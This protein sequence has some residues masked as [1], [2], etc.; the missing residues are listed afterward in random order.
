MLAAK[1]IDFEEID[2]SDPTCEDDKK[3]MRENS[4]PREGQRVPMPPQIFS[5]DEYLGV[6]A[7]YL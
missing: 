2:I 1:K 7:L 6:G 3:F 4:T 5:E